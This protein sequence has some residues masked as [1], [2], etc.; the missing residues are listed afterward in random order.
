[1]VAGSTHCIERYRS[2]QESSHTLHLTYRYV[3]EVARYQ[4]SSI[5]RL[6][7]GLSSD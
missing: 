1:V 5:F 6:E 3:R 7:P 2:G 4:R